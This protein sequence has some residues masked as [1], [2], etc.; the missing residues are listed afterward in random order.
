MIRLVV[1]NKT[2]KFVALCNIFYN[3]GLLYNWLYFWH[4]R[5]Q[6]IYTHD[7]LTGNL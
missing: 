7:C 3:C 5:K 1:K 4:E 2:K 6:K